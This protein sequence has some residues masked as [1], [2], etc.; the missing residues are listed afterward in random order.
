M[1]QR[2]CY[3]SLTQLSLLLLKQMLGREKDEVQRRHL[4]ILPDLI[5]VS[6]NRRFGAENLHRQVVLALRRF[7]AGTFLRRDVLAQ[8]L[9]GAQT[10][11]RRD[12]LA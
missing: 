2:S 9:F 6:L 10:F 1:V 4:L 12:I 11:G 3:E 5:Y 8:K 7:N